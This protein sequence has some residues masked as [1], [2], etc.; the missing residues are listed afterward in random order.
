VQSQ[1]HRQKPST[2]QVTEIRGD[3]VDS[4]VAHGEITLKTG[5]T[6]EE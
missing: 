6:V 1:G 2:F 4:K 3:I 5:F